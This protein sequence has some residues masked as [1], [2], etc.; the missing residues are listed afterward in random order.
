MSRTWSAGDLAER[1]T[2]GIEALGQQP[3][4]HPVESY[5]AFLRLL[6]QWGKAYNL[7]AVRAPEAMVTHLILD[8]LAVLPYVR[9]ARALDVGT[10]AG[11]PGL[12]LALARPAMHWTLLD[13][14]KKKIRFI[15]Q[16]IMDLHVT[17]VETVCSR[18]EEYRPAEL[19][20]TVTSRA[21][22][23]LLEFYTGARHL[24]APDGVLLAL[25]GGDISREI[26]EVQETRDAPALE[27]QALLVPGTEKKRCLV[28]MRTAR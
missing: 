27:V 17:N 8:S 13:S 1:I 20:S 12:V 25:K 26:R 14:R 6:D 23:S 4:L 15:N 28:E 16:A 3:R 24:L 21:F 11:I 18:V 2:A 22:G 5:V 19:F 10:G 7:T 9:G